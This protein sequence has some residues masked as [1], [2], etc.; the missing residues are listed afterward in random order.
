M[1]IKEKAPVK[2]PIGTTKL[3]CGFS[4][5]LTNLAKIVINKIAAGAVFAKLK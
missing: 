1:T 4:L 5:L 3:H 2:K